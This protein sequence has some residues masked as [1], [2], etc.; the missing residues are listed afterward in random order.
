MYQTDPPRPAKEFLPTMYDLPSENP[1][2]T[3]LP[4]EFHILQPQLLRE[5]FC[6][7]NFP[8][9]QIF[10]ATDL[11]LYYD[12][13][14]PLWYKRPDWFAVVGVSRLYEQQELRLSYVIWQEGV[15]PFVVV[16][17][18]SPGTE[19]EDLGKTLRD[20]NQPPTKWEVYE[21]V[22]RVPYYI[23]FDRYTYQLRA[24]QLQGSSYSELE[25]NQFRVWLNDIQLGLGLWNGFYQGI[26]RQ[27][28]RWY[29]A[30][31][32]WVLTPEERERKQK[33]RERQRAERLAEQ[34]RTLG[35]EP[36]VR[37]DEEGY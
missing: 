11:N 1:E 37:D 10:I 30:L 21:R 25:I 19:K 22:L 32:N 3:G 24:F 31:G 18:I 27:W 16:E 26:E 20:A 6:P 33:E 35:I 4:D 29:D 7:P 14:H 2:E 23:I 17:F 15:N 36:D 5:T 8:E 13:H 28:L 12:V 34:L 9:N